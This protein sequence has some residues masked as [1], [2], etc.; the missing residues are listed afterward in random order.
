MFRNSIRRFLGQPRD[1]HKARSVPRKAQ[2]AL[3][4]ESL[5]DRLV[6]AVFNVNS[7]A[8]MLNPTQGAVTLRS[9]IQAANATPGGNTINLT[10]PGTYEITVPGLFDNMN[11]TGD[12][13]ILASGGNLTIDN[14]SDGTVIIDGGGHDRIFDINPTFDP[15]NPTAT[16]PFKVTLQGL[17]LQDGI[18]APFGGGTMGGGAIRDTG[19]ASLELD[20]CIVTNNR[21]SGAGGGI[22]MQNTINTPWALT[23]NNTVISNNHAG[24]AGGG[25]DTIGSGKVFVTNSQL[26]EN[27]CVNQGAA[28]WLDTINGASATMTMTGTLVSRNDAVAGPTGA[29]GSAGD[30]PVTIASS[31]VSDNYSGSTGG[32]Y[33]DQGNAVNLTIIN[34]QFLNNLAATDGGAVQDGGP[35]TT[36]TIT[37][38]VFAGNT[39]EGNGGG[40][41]S[42]GGT[43]KI[44][45]T[46]FTANTASNGG[47]IEDQAAML[48]LSFSELDNN[49][50]VGDANGNGGNGGGLDARTGVPLV[51]VANSLFL[52]NRASN[53]GIGEGGAIS[54]TFGTLG[55][56]NSQFTGNIA[57]TGGGGIL[58]GGT[59]LTVTTSTFNDNQA[60]S[61][62]GGAIAVVSGL[63]S[64]GV[65]VANDSFIG[66]FALSVGGAVDEG[67]NGTSSFL[68]DTVIGNSS[69]VRGG[70]LELFPV[71][72][73]VDI[74]QNTIVASNTCPGSPD[75]D[76]NGLSVTDHGG[77]F[78]G[79]LTG[80]SGFGPGTLTGN[81]KLGPLQDNGGPF[82]GVPGF[83]Q[84]VQTEAL[85]PGSSAIGMGIK[86]V[87]PAI[88]ERG[89]PRP[90]AG[91]ANPSIGAYEP[92]YAT[93]ATANQVLVENFFEVLLGRL[94]DTGSA[95]FVSELNSG[96]S[97]STVVLQIEGS[98]EYLSDQVQLLYQRY[99]H[100]QADSG[101]LQSFISQLSHG[102]TL[103]QVAAVL[104]GSTE[105]FQL[106]GSNN[107]GFVSA[108]YL[109]ALGRT[110][111]PFG[112]D[113]FTQMLAGGASRT[114]VALAV[115][116]S[117]EY[118]S[119][120]VSQSFAQYLGRAAFPEDLTN[121]TGMLQHGLTDQ[122]L[123]AILLGSTEFSSN[124]T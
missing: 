20:N 71:A 74:L 106:H 109:D 87:G 72:N 85:L 30:G 91:A 111:D 52:N 16:A 64:A 114:A 94:T 77:N 8:D 113:S 22:L 82:A 60:D 46:R 61:G 40:F 101:G 47:G 115:F 103:E 90:G 17:T 50:A 59:S 92:Q 23:L 68:N 78:I 95:S 9:A 89:F 43:V 48:T 25:I 98:G 18:A 93:N 41:L 4:V 120:L 2:S 10:V 45:N 54:Q 53:G 67:T 7:M 39:A 70:G 117:Q 110:P 99:L 107:L 119:D 15:N 86:S 35:G 100:R 69:T 122:D 14:T 124:R 29:L 62:F 38:S 76:L 42:S 65:T 32:G 3:N 75:I 108:L 56:S 80:L 34:S 13:D 28:I 1:S 58:F 63:S 37:N 118:Q 27:T 116:S 21:A 83:G 51:S 104:V 6:P 26:V 12:F 112:Q 105:Y 5:E 97:A 49:D 44:S 57:S 96:I 88:D 73:S 11:K 84:V 33:G 19:N 121:F 31:T 102:A 81:P 36:T 79:N 55:V 24:D 66:N 123:V